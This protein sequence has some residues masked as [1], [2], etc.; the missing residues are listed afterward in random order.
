V[1]KEEIR[2]FLLTFADS[3]AYREREKLKFRPDDAVLEIYRA[4]Y[5]SKW[6]PDALEVETF[7]ARLEKQYCL[8]LA[9][10]WRD[11]LTL[12]EIFEATRRQ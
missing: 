7:A 1:R 12:G 2:A 5:P 11:T 10:I 6:M 4:H 8:S 3:F 9:H